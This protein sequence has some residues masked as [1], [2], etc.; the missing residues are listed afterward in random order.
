MN[1]AR[2]LAA[3]LGGLVLLATADAHA[4][5]R[6]DRHSGHQPRFN[7]ATYT[8]PARSPV[9]VLRMARAARVSQMARS[10]PMDA[11]VAVQEARAAVNPV[12]ASRFAQAARHHGLMRGS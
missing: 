11:H 10:A 4:A 7:A 8:V 6:R 2:I 9:R 12:P 1:A 5:R 3:A